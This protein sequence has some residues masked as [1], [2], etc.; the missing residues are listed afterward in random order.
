MFLYTS[1]QGPDL[2]K[3]AIDDLVILC[4]LMI[5]ISLAAQT[6]FFTWVRKKESVGTALY[7]C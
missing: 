7:R 5:I 3:D 2:S 4:K 1:F 6:A